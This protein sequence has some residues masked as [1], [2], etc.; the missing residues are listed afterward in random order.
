M[1]TL[2]RPKLWSPPAKPPPGQAISWGDPL[3][4]G[5]K[6]AW[7]ASSVSKSGPSNP[8]A[9]GGRDLVH[10]IIAQLPVY[11]TYGDYPVP[12][13]GAAGPG[14]YFNNIGMEFV[15]TKQYIP[16]QPPLTVVTYVDFVTTGLSQT[17]ASAGQPSVGGWYLKANNGSNVINF[18]KGGN[19]DVTSSLVSP[20]GPA[21][22]AAAVTST[23]VTFYLN[24]KVNVVSNSYSITSGNYDVMIGQENSGGDTVQGRISAV[25]IWNRCLRPEEIMRLNASPYAFFVPQAPTQRFW[26]VSLKG[27]CVDTLSFTDAPRATIQTVHAAD[28][29]AFRDVYTAAG[30]FDRLSLQDLVTYA[31]HKNHGT[32]ALLLSDVVSPLPVT[33]RL[34]GKWF[35]VGSGVLGGTTLIGSADLGATWQSITCPFTGGIVNCVGWNGAN[36]WIIGG[37]RLGVTSSTLAT[38]ID[39]TTWTTRS[40]SAFDG[41]GYGVKNVVWENNQWVAVGRSN[42]TNSCLATSF[43]G[44]NWTT[45]TT[46]FDGVNGLINDVAW[47]GSKWVAVGTSLSTACVAT[48]TN[49]TVWTRQVTPFDG[50]VLN[51]VVWTGSLWV[52][53]GQDSTGTHTIMTSSD[54]VNWTSRSTP[55]ESG[56][57]GVP[58]VNDLA[59]NG[60]LLVAVGSPQTLIDVVMTSTNGTSWVSGSSSFYTGVGKSVAYVPP[61]L[62]IIGGG[63]GEPVPQRLLYSVNGK[64]W[65]Q[66]VSTPF[67]S[68]GQVVGLLG[69]SI[70][71]V[72]T[73]TIPSFPAP[74]VG[75]R[76]GMIPAL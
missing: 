50:G 73:P 75:E 29:L 24:D 19:F 32:D 23:T 30:V 38:S 59:W 17:I 54:G 48:S 1:A 28:A 35:A 12:T 16:H 65:E 71:V 11:A 33:K 74:L 51:A 41:G 14:V 26:A 56:G 45:Q 69:P 58:I 46:P 52:V 21:M 27:L 25:Y 72:T 37:S 2:I 70:S 61:N 62:W 76:A 15:G 66:S 53:G 3:A 31:G 55:F 49:G 39:G 6:F 7:N 9:S 42:I 5:L 47:N 68:T 34:L 10:G 44:V 57:T 63:F 8:A 36:L 40:I 20:T 67:D 43:D 64:T 18:T 60:S 13:R 4:L 22:I